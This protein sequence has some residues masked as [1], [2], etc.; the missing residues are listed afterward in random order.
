MKLMLPLAHYHTIYLF[1]K[2]FQ[3]NL[4]FIRFENYFIF[5]GPFINTLSTTSWILNIFVTH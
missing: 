4:M 5:I 2:L 1:V 3:I